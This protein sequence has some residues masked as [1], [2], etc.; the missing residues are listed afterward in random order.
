MSR[1]SDILNVE[2]SGKPYHEVPYKIL[3]DKSGYVEFLREQGLSDSAIGRERICFSS[4]V[5]T[6]DG[7]D[8]NWHEHTASIDV[9]F[10]WH[11]TRGDPEVASRRANNNLLHETAHML[12]FQLSKEYSVG[13]TALRFAANLAGAYLL[14]KAGNSFMRG[15]FFEPG[16]I[17]K[18]VSAP[19][20]YYLTNKL[21]SYLSPLEYRARKFQQEHKDK[22]FV[23][24]KAK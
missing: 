7:G 11:T 20:T 12:D 22:T 3:F 16:I 13:V 9:G 6:I 21:F 18:L 15:N 8:Y 10:V 19:L 14:Y 24:L 5:Y 4:K 17:S 23:T 1:E 2:Y